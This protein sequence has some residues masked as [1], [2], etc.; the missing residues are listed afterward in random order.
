[1][2][3]NKMRERKTPYDQYNQ[4]AE[5]RQY[6]SHTLITQTYSQQL[7]IPQKNNNPQITP[8][9]P[10]Q[11]SQQSSM[12]SNNL[13]ES[14]YLQKNKRNKS[15]APDTKKDHCNNCNKIGHIKKHCSRNLQ[16]AEQIICYNCKNPGH[17]KKDCPRNWSLDKS[18]K[19]HK[20]LFVIIVKNLAY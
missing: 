13:Q 11:K 7:N 10:N 8:I 14:S 4:H 9:N 15:P 18:N 6:H 5:I 12:Q 19:Y 3:N 16:Q 20:L 1:M 17:I 2:S